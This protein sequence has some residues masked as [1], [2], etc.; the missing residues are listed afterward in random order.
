MSNRDSLK[1]QNNLRIKSNISAK[2]A[3][4]LADLDLSNLQD[5]SVLVYSTDSGKWESTI[6]L[7]KQTIECGQY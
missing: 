3:S 1:S 6:L 4:E 5:G 7:E 2:R